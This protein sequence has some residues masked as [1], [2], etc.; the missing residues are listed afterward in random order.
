MIFSHC[1]TSGYWRTFV[2]TLLPLTSG[3]LREITQQFKILIEYSAISFQKHIF[4]PYIHMAKYVANLLHR[5]VVTEA[6]DVK[7]HTFILFTTTR[8]FEYFILPCLVISWFCRFLG[9]QK[10]QLQ[11]GSQ[12][13]TRQAEVSQS[14][15]V[16]VLRFCFHWKLRGQVRVRLL[17]RAA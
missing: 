17:S 7:P 16:S 13:L 12:M 9:N 15:G 2:H 3:K 14:F 10:V 11:C 5:C 4:K 1:N 6:F 8:Q